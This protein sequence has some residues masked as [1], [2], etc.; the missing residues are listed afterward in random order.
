MRRL[1]RSTRV[2]R[3]RV[4]WGIVFLAAATAVG[5][6]FP[7]C[8]DFG[9]YT[10]AEKNVAEAGARPTVSVDPVEPAVAPSDGGT[11]VGDRKLCGGACV[12]NSDPRYGCGDGCA[13]CSVPHGAAG[14]HAGAC[15]VQSC[16]ANRADCNGIVSDD[17]ELDLALSPQGCGLCDGGA[18]ACPRKC[19]GKACG[20]PDDCGGK[21]EGACGDGQKCVN[22]QCIC[23]ATTCPNGCCGA[24]GRCQPGDRAEACGKGGAACARCQGGGACAA[25]VCG[26]PLPRAVCTTQPLPG[27]ATCS[28]VCARAFGGGGGERDRRAVCTT[29]CFEADVVGYVRTDAQCTAHDQDTK[30]TDCEQQISLD[31]TAGVHCCCK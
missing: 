6:T 9:D 5:L 21:C 2:E 14:C 30:L 29:G 27:E 28:R 17:C 31:G 10:L 25:G 13:P 15:V 22:A 8:A 3:R 1:C 7:A 16:E 4:T 11:C 24:R 12:S 23:D 20:E 26:D 18:C 19:G